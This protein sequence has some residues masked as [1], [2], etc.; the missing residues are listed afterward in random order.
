MAFCC[1]T[2]MLPA[3]P[4]IRPGAVFLRAKELLRAHHRLH[5]VSSALND[6]RPAC[7]R[8]FCVSL[9]PSATTARLASE[10]RQ[11]A[12]ARNSPSRRRASSRP[13][14]WAGSTGT[15]LHDAQAGCPHA[16]VLV[17]SFEC[18]M[19]SASPWERGGGGDSENES[20]QGGAPCVACARRIVGLS[21]MHAGV[22]L[23]G[24]AL[25]LSRN[26]GV[27]NG[28]AGVS[29]VF[30]SRGRHTFLRADCSACLVCCGASSLLLCCCNLSFPDNPSLHRLTC[31]RSVGVAAGW[32]EV[33]PKTTRRCCCTHRQ[34]RCP[35]S[36]ASGHREA[37]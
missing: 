30:V 35:C 6:D 5:P 32:A 36:Q 23:H 2:A 26:A 15:C 9:H 28:V 37:A 11:Y 14:R 16:A 21:A 18:G 27:L 4:T 29:T 12:T 25:C 3:R 17:W 22:A 8:R 34:R 19:S 24:T 31:G 1:S 33:V 13:G 7:L 10:R 20:R